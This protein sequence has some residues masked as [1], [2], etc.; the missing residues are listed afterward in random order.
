MARH[1]DDDEGELVY[2]R[3]VGYLGLSPVAGRTVFALLRLCAISLETGSV[4][5]ECER[6][7]INETGEAYLRGGHHGTHRPEV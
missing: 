1:R 6:Y 7:R 5:G 2:E 4:I 3:G